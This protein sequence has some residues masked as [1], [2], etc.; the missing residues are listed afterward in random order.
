[1]GWLDA[2][3]GLA[4]IGLS[5]W[6][7]NEQADAIEDRGEA[8]AAEENRA[9]A[10]NAALSHEDARITRVEAFQV[11]QATGNKIHNFLEM[12]DRTFSTA[13]RNFARSGVV[14][15]TVDVVLDDIRRHTGYQHEIIRSNGEKAKQAKLELAKRYEQLADAGLR[16]GAAAA[17]LYEQ[18]AA[19]EAS[20]T[21]WNTWGTALQDGYKLTTS[22]WG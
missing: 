19:S 9:A 20:A 2:A 5:L 13:R 1:M 8:Q 18:A 22:I 7:G 15:A 4:G 21:R 3:V 17:S 11:E 16:E 6:Q 14:G 10:A 12:A